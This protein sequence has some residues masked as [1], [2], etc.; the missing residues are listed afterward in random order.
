MIT[1]ARKSTIDSKTLDKLESKRNEVD[2]ISFLAEKD[3][4]SF[5]LIG[6]SPV[7]KKNKRFRHNKN[8]Y[9]TTKTE[10]FKDGTVPICKDCIKMYVYDTDG[11]VNMANF[12]SVLKLM[13]LPYIQ[14]E[15]EKAIK[16]NKDVFGIYKAN[17]KYNPNFT[18]DNSSHLA[19]SAT[20]IDDGK[21]IDIDIEVLRFDWGD[22]FEDSAL[23]WLEQRF[24]NWKIKVKFDNDDFSSENMVRMICLKELDIRNMRSQGLPVNKEEETLLKMLD[25]AKLTVKSNS[26]KK[27]EKISPLGVRIADIEL[28]TPAEVF[29]DRKLFEDVDGVFDYF[30]RFILRPLINYVSGSRDMDKEFNVEEA[31]KYVNGED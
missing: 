28:K 12:K 1:I 10:M 15:F 5:C 9:A 3:D 18:Y 13:D 14:T 26:D 23:Y 7:C 31:E 4:H 19:T 29:E 25:G 30:K 16:T 17:V 24:K 22:H 6:C 11:N 21:P 2:K 8:Y 20:F 27:E